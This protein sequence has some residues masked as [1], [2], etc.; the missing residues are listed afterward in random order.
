MVLVSHNY[1]YEIDP[2]IFYFLKYYFQKIVFKQDRILSASIWAILENKVWFPNIERIIRY[3]TMNSDPTLRYN[4]QF[5]QKYSEEMTQPQMDTFSNNMSNMLRVLCVGPQEDLKIDYV[6]PQGCPYIDDYP[7]SPFERVWEEETG[8]LHPDRVQTPPYS[9]ILPIGEYGYPQWLE[10]FVASVNNTKPPVFSFKYNQEDKENEPVERLEG[11]IATKFTVDKETIKNLVEYIN[12][13]KY[14][15]DYS[16]ALE[17]LFKLTTPEFNDLLKGLQE[18]FIRKR[19]QIATQYLI[20]S[21]EQEFLKYFLPD[22]FG[23]NNITEL[24]KILE[25]RQP[26]FYD[27]LK[28]KIIEYG[29][30]DDGLSNVPCNYGHCNENQKLYKRI[31]EIDPWDYD[32]KITELINIFKEMTEDALGGGGYKHTP[33]NKGGRRKS[34]GGRRKSK[35]GRR[36][37]KGGI[38]QRR[39]LSQSPKRSSPKR[40]SR[41]G[42]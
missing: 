36:K 3:K 21:N 26:E 29:M 2:K 41:G 27:L 23:G 31:I 5:D 34:K 9:S 42:G 12:E 20:S 14:R 13:Q 8:R 19:D 38:Q 18:L 28:N 1:Q 11:E 35:G 16:K 17:Y 7:L 4:N 39:K 30:E 10:Q 22:I 24:N 25:L 37:S 40:S 6:L 33:H 15:L 32:Y